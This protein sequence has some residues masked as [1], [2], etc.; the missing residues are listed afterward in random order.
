LS[1]TVTSESLLHPESTEHPRIEVRAWG[2]RG[3]L[4]TP[5]LE[6]LGFGGNTPCVEIKFGNEAGCRQRLIF[7]AGTGIRNL[8]MH[9]LKSQCTDTSFHVFLTHFHWDHVQGLPFFQALYRKETTITFYSNR[10]PEDLKEILWGQMVTPYFPVRF[11]DIAATVHFVQ[12]LETPLV[13]GEVKVNSFCLTHPQGSSGFCV[14]YRGKKIVYATDHEHGQEDADLRLLNASKG[15]DLLFYDA[16]YTPEE[17]PNRMGWGHGTWLQ[18][19]RVAT[20]AEVKQLVLFHHDP[21]HNDVKMEAILADARSKF[22][23]T[24]AAREGETLIVR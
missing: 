1:E 17:Y 10:T 11:S 15:A 22:A 13:L 12:I 5:S 21:S 16:Q 24:I 18:A 7:D 9:L 19:T 8:G 3:S 4:P 14:T 2:V 6:V 20:A 23:C